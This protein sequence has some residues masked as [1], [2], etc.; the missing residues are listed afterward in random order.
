MSGLASALGLRVALPMKPAA[1][2]AQPAT[3]KLE[4]TRRARLQALY[5]ANY[6]PVWRVL[7]RVGLDAAH[8]ADV[9]HQT[10]LVA[11]ERLDDIEPGK[12]KAFLC[13][14][15]VRIAQKQHAGNREE[16]VEE[17]PDQ[18]GGARPDDETEQARLRRLLDGLLAKLPNDLRVALVLH[19]VEGYSQ[20]EIAQ[21]LEIPD[22]TAASRLRRA[23]ESFD[24]LL[25]THLK[26]VQP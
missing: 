16:L 3:V 10:F 17:L 2:L 14:I 6:D 19:D 13:A 25:S 23:R 7:R 18:P 8:A 11:L 24:V 26:Q 21:M 15:A 9:A 1:T 5:E 4:T 12:D 20:R 22:G